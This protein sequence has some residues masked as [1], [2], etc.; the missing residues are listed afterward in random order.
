MNQGEEKKTILYEEHVNLG[1]K[2]TPYGGYLMPLQ[3]EGILA[4]HR[5]V[6]EG[7]G[8]F[9]VS[10]M[11]EFLIKGSGA[12]AF[13]D[14]LLTNP[15]SNLKL[16]RVR[17]SP[18]CYET[19]GTV[20]DLVVY[21]LEDG[22]ML[23]VNAANL[24]K[25]A[26]W[27]KSHLPEEGVSFEDVSSTTSL[28]AVQ[29]PKSKDVMESIGEGLPTRFFS[30]KSINLLG[31][32]VLVSRTGYTGEYGYEIYGSHDAI[33]ELWAV[34]MDKGVKPCGLGARDTL[35][36]EAGL[37]LYGNELSVDIRP[38]EAGLSFAIKLDR[39]DFV[40]RSVLIE[41]SDREHVRLKVEGRGLV[42]S[43]QEL[44]AGDEKIGVITSG[45]QAPTLGY[46]IGMALVSKD[47]PDAS[48]Q[49]EARGR[50]IP[51]VQVEDNFLD[52]R[53]DL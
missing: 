42:R 45:T 17:Y 27:I 51:V 4:E 20:D 34:L 48:W 13:L 24:A 29:G 47:R 44:F 15:I 7:V 23:V 30:Y 41:P 18:M 21:A 28:L 50:M 43:G 8:V 49:V 31:H 3:Y 25:D 53:E 11:G 40:G 33:K 12:A 10:H 2:M 37:P 39:D 16:G 36:L 46:G 6:R 1:A 9:D 35:R 38:D 22:Y 52:H 5:A 14:E 26:E 32:E 19:G